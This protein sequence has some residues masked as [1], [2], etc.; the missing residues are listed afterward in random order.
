LA[1]KLN[2]DVKVRGFH[3][4]RKVINNTDSANVV[5]TFFLFVFRQNTVLKTNRLNIPKYVYY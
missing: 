4:G 2:Y 3:G 5:E 1:I